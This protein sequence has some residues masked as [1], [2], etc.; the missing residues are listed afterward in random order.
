LRVERGASQILFG[1]LPGQ[2][3]D[4]GGGVWKVSRWNDPSEVPFDQAGLRRA[5]LDAS[6]A[7]SAAEAN[8][9]IWSELQRGAPIDVVRL[10][11]RLGIE[12]ET[13][14]RLWRCR[15]C[16][17][18]TNRASGRCA[19]GGESR[20]QL[21]YVQYHS[22]G[23]LQEPSLQRCPV[24]NEVAMSLPGS[25][26]VRDLRFSC[27]S[28]NRVLSQGFPF[29]NCGCGTAPERLERNVHRAA[30]VFTPRFAVMIN[31]AD[32]GKATRM[33][34][35][36]GGAQALQWVLGGMEGDDP[37]SGPPTVASFTDNLLRQGFTLE[38][39]REFAQLALDGG[40]IKSA[41]G[42]MPALDGATSEAA[43]EEA[44]GL[45]TAVMEGRTT[46]A[47]MV[48]KTTPP[49]RTLYEGRYGPALESVHLESVD[50]L[51]KFPIATLAFGFTRG[52]A[53]PGASRLVA[54]RERGRLRAY[55][56]VHPTEALLFR[57]RPD[58][59]Y[60]Y[61][62]A[63]GLVEPRKV[64]AREGRSL[65][66]SSVH[67][68][69]AID[70][71]PQELGRAATEL[72]HSY[73]HRAIRRLA[74]FAGTDRDSLGEYLLPHHFAFVIYAAARGDFVLG[75]LQAVFESSLHEFL[76]DFAFGEHRC[77]LDP[78]CTTGG[79]ACMACLHLGEAS[80]RWFNRF[81]DRRRLFG[82]TG[83]LRR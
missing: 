14:P 46:I 61:L 72:V 27:P 10:N 28:C 64:T 49:L 54:F 78:G 26:A 43:Q 34:A 7:W 75:G 8:D 69:R 77:P 42:E 33:R 82:S 25:S 4:I 32:P 73:A 52:D 23:I 71:D 17:R 13:F 63:L 44:L 60:A 3:V 74:A 11:R 39:A 80:C 6:G 40:Q 53:R 56:D 29:R 57:L 38:K 70:E 22:C 18:V 66:L 30:S 1:F 47:G 12:V 50:F 67:I 24:H 48:Q 55:G 16:G 81:L 79:A 76:E 41:H 2:T 21:H 45:A 65:V 51:P 83:F 31:P 19:C 62:A 35:S 20:S 37:M 15:R 58:H 9:G 59:V 5:L 68:P 36:G